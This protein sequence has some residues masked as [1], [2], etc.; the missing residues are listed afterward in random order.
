[1]IRVMTVACQYNYNYSKL[2]GK[3]QLHGERVST[4][5]TLPKHLDHMK[6]T[7][8]D[9]K[10]KINLISYSP[11]Q[12]NL[13]LGFQEIKTHQ[14]TIPDPFAASISHAIKSISK[15]IIFVMLL[16]IPTIF[17]SCEHNI[18][19]LGCSLQTSNQI[20]SILNRRVLGCWL[21]KCT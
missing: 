11:L 6:S 1:M 3:R 8:R 13:K 10:G 16:P 7:N 15:R 9:L 4:Y 19:A 18:E 12:K 14:K 2:V 21:Q 5:F 17:G 20:Y